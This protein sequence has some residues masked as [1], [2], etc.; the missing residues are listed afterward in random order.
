MKCEPLLEKNLCTGLQIVIVGLS[1][2]H[3]LQ[4]QVRSAHE[5]VRSSRG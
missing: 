3:F 4:E 5:T 1:L 2:H